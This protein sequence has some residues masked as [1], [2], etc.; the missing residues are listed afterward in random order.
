M[1]FR[2]DVLPI[3][4]TVWINGSSYTIEYE[5]GNGGANAPDSLEDVTVSIPFSSAEPNVQSFD[6]KY[7]MTGDSLDWTIGPVNGD[8][9]TGSFEFEAA[10]EDESEF[11]PMRV[12]FSK[13]TPYQDISVDSVTLIDEGEEMDFAKDIKSVATQSSFL[14]E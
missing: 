6:A 4:F 7:E 10:G 3:T 1:L 5:L 13:S 9:P 12:S 14:I 11:F 8:N 2:S